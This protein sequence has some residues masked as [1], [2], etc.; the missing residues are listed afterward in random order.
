MVDSNTSRAIA[1]NYKAI[2]KKSFNEDVGSYFRV[3]D[4]WSDCLSVA[5]EFYT[6]LWTELKDAKT[7]CQESLAEFGVGDLFSDSVADVLDQDLGL[8]AEGRLSEISISEVQEA[9]HG[10]AEHRGN[11]DLY[12]D[13]P[14]YLCE[15]PSVDMIMIDFNPGVIR[16]CREGIGDDGESEVHGTISLLDRDV[17]GDVESDCFKWR[18]PINVQPVALEIGMVAGNRVEQNMSVC[19]EVYVNTTLSEVRVGVG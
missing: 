1:I 4:V 19:S 2:K 17:N 11:I 12:A 3:S 8:Q 10:S 9:D 15:E 16:V 18:Q 7:W 5:K 13:K 6:D 14:E